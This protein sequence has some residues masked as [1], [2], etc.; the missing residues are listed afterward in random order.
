MCTYPQIG[1]YASAR[2]SPYALMH[3][4]A[5]SSVASRRAIRARMRTPNGCVACVRARR[6]LATFANVR[7]HARARKGIECRPTHR[8]PSPWVFCVCWFAFFFCLSRL[9]GVH[10]SHTRRNLNC[11]GATLT[12]VCVCCVWCFVSSTRDDKLQVSAHRL[13]CVFLNRTAPSSRA[14]TI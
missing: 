8:Q 14:L 2:H 12:R 3:G 10:R 5:P 6:S 7:T 1:F 13:R 9:F 4:W 11:A